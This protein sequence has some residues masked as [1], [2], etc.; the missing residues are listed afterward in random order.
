MMVRDRIGWLDEEDYISDEE[1]AL[2]VQ[3]AAD[4][5]DDTPDPLDSGYARRNEVVQELADAQGIV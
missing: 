1:T 4:A 3:D 5:A 2:E